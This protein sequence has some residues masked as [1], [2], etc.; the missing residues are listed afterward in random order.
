MDE[1]TRYLYQN[2]T[3]PAGDK[4]MSHTRLADNKS[5]KSGGKWF[6]P[7]DKLSEFYE[8]YSKLNDNIVDRLVERHRDDHI[9]PIIIDFDIKQTNETDVLTGDIINK[10]IETLTNEI[11]KICEGNYECYVLKRKFPYKKD[12]IYKNGLHIYFPSIVTRYE[13][14]YYLREQYMPILQEIIGSFILDPIEEVY[15]S[16]VIKDNGLIM[17]RSSKADVPEYIIYDVYNGAQ[18]LNSK[19]E[20][21]HKLS[22]RNKTQEVTYKMQ[23][24]F[25]KYNT[26]KGKPKKNKTSTCRYQCRE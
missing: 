2:F 22:I 5:K 12:D 11:K 14:Q 21:L 26:S 18:K 15:D 19:L 23:I 13:Y 16:S 7:D 10:I 1:F 24:D 8:V 9:S 4:R 6:I 17:Y 3:V 25:E 20:Y